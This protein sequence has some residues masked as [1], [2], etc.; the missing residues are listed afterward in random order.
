MDIE[1]STAPR[2]VAVATIAGLDKPGPER[3]GRIREGDTEEVVGSGPE[4]GL[5][6]DGE[7]EEETRRKETG[8]AQMTQMLG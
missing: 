7:E 3:I 5:I 1:G 4:T 8:Q 2:L 6:Q